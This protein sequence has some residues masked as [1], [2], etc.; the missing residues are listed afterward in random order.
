MQSVFRIQHHTARD[1]LVN[2][3]RLI[4]A[5]AVFAGEPGHQVLNTVHFLRAQDIP[6]AIAI[7]V[8]CVEPAIILPSVIEMGIPALTHEAAKAC[9]SFVHCSKGF[10]GPAFVDL[11]QII[12]AIAISVH[13]EPAVGVLTRVIRTPVTQIL[14]IR[15]PVQ[16]A[17]FAGACE[18]KH[19]PAIDVSQ[20]PNTRVAITVFVPDQN[21]KLF[22]AARCL[23]H[24]QLP[25]R[26]EG[27]MG[28]GARCRR[29]VAH[30][31]GGV[32]FPRGGA[33]RHIS[34]QRMP[35][36]VVFGVIEIVGVQALVIKVCINSD[37]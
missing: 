29:I 14:P 17:V 9:L 33:Q 30:G 8:S 6:P 13:D 27:D 3:I 32:A 37:K 5:Q 31:Q 28:L 21:T 2:V 15:S 23:A 35:I 16:G 26:G 10:I 36:V 7:D 34:E 11:H 18:S 22:G 20:Q 25:I 24:I 1:I 4:K 12:Q 19:G